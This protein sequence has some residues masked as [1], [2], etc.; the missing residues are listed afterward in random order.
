MAVLGTQIIRCL[1][2]CRHSV[3][4]P[5]LQQAVELLSAQI[6]LRRRVRVLVTSSNVG[7]AVIG[8]FRPLIILPEAITRSASAES[9]HPVLM[10]ELIHIRRGD[11]WLGFL[12]ATA[13]LIW[14]FHPL[15]HWTVRQASRSAEACCDQES[16]AALNCSPREYAQCLLTILEQKKQLTPIPSFPG[17]RAVDITSIR[18]EQIM[19]TRQGSLRN[20][21]RWSYGVLLLSALVILPGAAFVANGDDGIQIVTEP[22]IPERFASL[23]EEADSAL[24]PNRSPVSNSTS[25]RASEN[26]DNLVLVSLT[27]SSERLKGN[28]VVAEIN[29]RPLFVD[30]LVGSIRLTIEADERYTDAQRRQILLQQMKTRLDQRVDEEIVLH[31]LEGKVPEEQRDALQE[32]IEV[33]LGEFLKTRQASLIAEGKIQ[34]PEEMDQFLAQGGLSVGLLR[35]TFFRIQMVNGYIQ[36][37]TEQ[38]QGGAPDRLQLLDYYREHIADFTPEE[39]L[40]W[41]EIRVSFQEQG[42]REPAKKRMMEVIAQLKIDQTKFGSIARKYSDALSAEDDGNRGW[43]T[44]G[45]LLDQ[46]LENT[47]FA[48]SDNGRTAVVEVDGYFSIYRI[49]KHEY[50]NAR[51]FASVQSE[52]EVTICRERHTEARTEVF[53]KLRDAASV[54][55]IFDEDTGL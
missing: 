17:V 6:G 30:D 25:A 3:N 49:A 13:R 23:T 15:V 36:S 48:L 11:L 9:L 20:R 12:Q 2:L 5:E 50:A 16:L 8:I 10:H 40:R 43:L 52:I 44:R 7:P 14:W 46:E 24:M 22:S 19:K 32:H 1:M 38:A 39:R 29:G 28:S 53:K 34:S 47:L 21:K 42:G 45:A 55:T 54:R 35:E 18:L 4:D 33:Y 27:D 26:P 37:L 31:A 51:P 41:Q